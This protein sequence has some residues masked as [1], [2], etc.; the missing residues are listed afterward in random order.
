MAKKREFNVFSLSFLDVMS[1]G[2]GAVILIYIIIH[3]STEVTSQ[4]LNL[5]LMAEVKKLEEEVLRDTEDL[6]QIKNVLNQ[7]DDQIVT[8]EGM[9]ME[10]IQALGDLR[11]QINKMDLSGSSQ[12][13]SI[14]KLKSELKQLDEEAA[15]LEGSVGASETSGRNVRSIAG[16]GDRQYLTGLRIGGQHILILLD[17]S[18]SMLDSTIVNVIRLRN[19]SDGKKKQSGK[20]QRAIRTV[21]WLIANMPLNANYQVYGFNTKAGPLVTKDLSPWMETTDKESTNKLL[22]S[23]KSIVPADGTSL[24]A[25]FSAAAKLEPKPDNIFLIADGLPTQGAIP[26]KSTSI[27]SKDRVLLFK[28]SLQVLP[29]HIPVNVILF[30]MEGDPLAAP[31]FWQLAQSSGGSFLSPSKDWP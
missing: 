21:E 4:E 17:T 27:S 20:W 12:T 7:T 29:E 13:A 5:E 23:L 30:P 1:C 3:H 11:S 25:A 8:T 15:T 28:D 18:A 6:A 26:P 16:E 10:I 31:S 19:M 9:T 22:K 2:F 24:Q 14:E